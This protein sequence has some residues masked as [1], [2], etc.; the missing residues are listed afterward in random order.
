MYGKMTVVFMVK[1]KEAKAPATSSNAMRNLRL[2]KVVLNIGLRESGEAVEKAYNFLKSLSQA[3]P[4]K[5][6][7]GKKARTFRVRRGL[8]IGVKVTLRRDEALVLLKKVLPAVDS[9]IHE[10]AFDNEGNFSFGI[11][12][13]L[14]IPGQKYDPKIGVLGL[15]V[16]ASLERNG[17]R[18]KLRKIRKSI[19]G[20]KHRISKQEAIAFTKDVLGIKVV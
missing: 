8:P 10:T 3:K 15:N 5:T 12:E 11:K 19:V 6:L 13:H 1:V 4:V 9:R 20:K 16:N 14:D 7:A 2:G 18:I 17:S